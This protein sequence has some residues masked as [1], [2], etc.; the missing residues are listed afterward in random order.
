MTSTPATCLRAC[1]PQGPRVPFYG[2]NNMLMPEPKGR[3]GTAQYPGAAW[4]EATARHCASVPCASRRWHGPHCSHDVRHDEEC[5]GLDDRRHQERHLRTS[6]RRRP[7][8]RRR[9]TGLTASPGRG[10]ENDPDALAQ[11]AAGKQLYEERAR[12]EEQLRTATARREAAR[13]AGRAPGLKDPI[14]NE[15]AAEVS[16]LEAQ[17]ASN[18]EMIKDH[19]RRN[20]PEFALE[21]VRQK[22]EEQERD[23]REKRAATPTREVFSDYMPALPVVTGGL[24]LLAVRC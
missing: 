3:E 18:A 23:A 17:K 19:V 8:R 12:I 9:L 15:A 21:M 22:A 11:A 13:P 10:G 2:E 5:A 24:A 1:R 4:D 16:K 7:L 14:F 20:S 6:R